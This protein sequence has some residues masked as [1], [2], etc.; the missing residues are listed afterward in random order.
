MN[1]ITEKNSIQEEAQVE[2]DVPL[3]HADNINKLNQIKL[4]QEII[5][6]LENHQNNQYKRLISRFLTESAFKL[7]LLIISVMLVLYISDTILINLGLKS[8]SLLSQ[9]FELFKYIA[10][11]LIGYLFASNLKKDN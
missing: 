3:S 5:N 9:I 10:T 7:L 6:A 1:L 8:S 2:L 11:T 4:D